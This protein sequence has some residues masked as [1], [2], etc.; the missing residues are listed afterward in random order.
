MINHSRRLPPQA[1]STRVL[2]AAVSLSAWFAIREPRIFNRRVEQ[3][4]ARRVHTP[5]VAGSSPASATS[6]DRTARQGGVREPRRLR[7][8][9]FHARRFPFFSTSVP[10]YLWAG[11]FFIYVVH[12]FR[13]CCCTSFG[14]NFKRWLRS[15]PYVNFRIF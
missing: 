10:L 15:A 8:S 6:F 11:V 14:F 12:I 9:P 2:A 13:S 4:A 3:L 5:E 1:I 7:S